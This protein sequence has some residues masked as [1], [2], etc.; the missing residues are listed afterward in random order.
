[1]TQFRIHTDL[2][3]F[4][5]Q[6]DLVGKSVLIS[7]SLAQYARILYQAHHPLISVHHEQR[8]M[9]DKFWNDLYKPHMA[10]DVD[11]I[12]AQYDSCVQNGRHCRV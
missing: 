1:M 10:G 6:K 11:T 3:R 9:Y 4:H 8:R 12:I 5:V 2:Q 7:V